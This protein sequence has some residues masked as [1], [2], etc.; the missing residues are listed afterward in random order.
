M[1]YQQGDVILEKIEG[2]VSGK[3]LG[4]LILARGEATGHAHRVKADRRG[5]RTAALYR[6]RQ[7]MYLEVGAGGATIVH[8]EHKPV[9][10]PEGRYLVRQVREYDHFAEEVRRVQD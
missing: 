1:L 7:R 4:H 6:D 2:P 8:E 5:G 3:K 9:A 10:V